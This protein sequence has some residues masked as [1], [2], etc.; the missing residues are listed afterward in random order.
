MLTS[1]QIEAV[2]GDEGPE[3]PDL[4]PGTLAVGRAEFDRNLE[5]ARVPSPSIREEFFEDLG[6]EHAR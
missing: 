2:L 3:W 6:P 5:R 4:A 1:E